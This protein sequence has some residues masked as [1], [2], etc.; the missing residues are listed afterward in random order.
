MNKIDGT[1]KSVRELFTG[2]KYTIHYYQR[3][4]QWQHK[5]IEEL[6]SDLTEGFYEHHSTDDERSRVLNYGHYFMG[7]I[8]LTADENAI[9]DGQQ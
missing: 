4:Y 5:Q 7:S 2:V 8:V 3:E 6:L 9:I 1:P